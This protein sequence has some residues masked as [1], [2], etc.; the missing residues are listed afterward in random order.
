VF[1]YDDVCFSTFVTA[2]IWTS[3]AAYSLCLNRRHRKIY[4]YDY[5]YKNQRW[6]PHYFIIIYIPR[7][8]GFYIYN[9]IVA[10]VSHS[11]KVTKK[12]P[13]HSAVII[14]ASINEKLSLIQRTPVSRILWFRP[15]CYSKTILG[16]QGPVK[17]NRYLR[18]KKRG[19]KQRPAS[20]SERHDI[21][22]TMRGQPPLQVPGSN[23]IYNAENRGC[24]FS[25]FSFATSVA[26]SDSTLQ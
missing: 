21:K 11:H 4:D 26:C 9:L 24:D 20:Q 2:F 18:K 1:A 17:E 8:K 3:V 12:D 14:L 10:F 19:K 6:K 16:S 25:Q 23:H 22:M 15:Y 5:D 7:L 13:R